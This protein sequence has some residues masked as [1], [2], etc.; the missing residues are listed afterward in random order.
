MAQFTKHG[1]QRLRERVEKLTRSKKEAAMLQP[2][3]LA[4]KKG[5]K[6]EEFDEL[7]KGVLKSAA[8]KGGG[9]DVR[10][11]D[12]N[13]YLFT[14]NKKKL[15]TVL[16]VLERY[17]PWENHLLVN[18]EKEKEVLIMEV[19]YTDAELI[20]LK[21]GISNCPE[22]YE[23]YCRFCKTW[24]S[25]T[26]FGKDSSAKDG[27]RNPCKDCDKIMKDSNTRKEVIAELKTNAKSDKPARMVKLIDVEKIKINKTDV[28]LRDKVIN[29]KDCG[30][31]FVFT[32][33]EQLHFAQRG[34]FT[35]SRCL[36]CRED[37]R[38]KNGTQITGEQKVVEPAVSL[39]V[40]E[41]AV[42]VVNSTTLSEQVVN[43][44]SILKEYDTTLQGIENTIIMYN[45][46]SKEALDVVRAVEGMK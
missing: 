22:D 35:P 10:L 23:K 42:S 19:K 13:I 24:K 32:Y 37:N 17:Q 41:P 43:I 12:N 9:L 8:A 25:C 15:V 6:P 16:N 40:K 34:W 46:W 38:I 27:L 30:N 26:E 36:E 29:C 33:P 1:K 39:E 45:S 7:L 28:G 5:H 21:T 14:K 31:D 18:I 2:F 20:C 3:Q 44:L 11:Y 4:I